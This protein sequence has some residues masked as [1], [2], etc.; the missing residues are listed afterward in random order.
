MKGIPSEGWIFGEELTPI[1]VEELPPNEFFFDKKRKAIV[2]QELYREAGTV[3]KK[4]K[5]LADGKAMKKGE[6][7]TQIVGT[8]GDFATTNQYSVRSLKEQ[9]TR[10]NR[11]IRTL[12]VKLATTEATV[13]DQVNTGLELVRAADQKEIER[14][15]SDLEQTQLLAQTS[16]SQISQ[17]EE[18]IGQL[19]AKLNFT[20]SQVIDIRIFQS[21]AIEIQRRVSVAQ[22]D[23]LAKVETIQNHCQIIDQVLEDISLREREVWGG[24]T[25]FPR[26]CHSHGEK[27]NG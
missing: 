15:K 16:Q 7:T 11:L 26:G 2:K 18:L 3:A 5:I 20:E 22:Q 27:G 8:L 6:F 17:Q 13:K 10:K 4:F 19:H 24:S 9:L 23:L 21:Q 14:L 25:H 1:T 12:E